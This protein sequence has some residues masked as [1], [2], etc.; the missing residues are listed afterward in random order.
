MVAHPLPARP[1][2]SARGRV[3]VLVMAGLLGTMACDGGKSSVSGPA[4]TVD[5]QP[6]LPADAAPDVRTA[7]VGPAPDR[8]ISP[9]DGPRDAAPPPIDGPVATDA[10]PL[11]DHPSLP[12]DADTSDAAPVVEG[13]PHLRLLPSA[14]MLREAREPA[15]VQVTLEGDATEAR[16]VTFD[17]PG[18][19][20]DP[21]SVTLNADTRQAVVHLIAPVDADSDDSR[22]RLTANAPDLAPVSVPYVVR[23]AHLTWEMVLDQDQLNFVRNSNDKGTRLHIGTRLN[24]RDAPGATIN[25]RGKGTL[26]CPRR[27]FTVRFDRPVQIQDSPPL[28][29]V[30]LI[31]LCEDPLVIRSRISLEML[32][33]IG[34]FPSW[35]TYVELQ[36]GGGTRGVYMLIERPRNAIARQFP[37]NTRVLR[38]MNDHDVEIDEPDEAFIADREAFLAS[39]STLYTLRSQFQ[40]EALLAELQRRMMYDQYLLWLAYNSVMA[41]GDYI[42]ELYVYDRGPPAD[43][44]GAE[45]TFYGIMPWDQDEIFRNCHTPAPINEP[46]LNCAES[47]LDGLVRS[48][49]PIRALYVRQLRELMAG[50]LE[51]GTMEVVVARAA[52]ELAVYLARPGVAAMH[53]VANMP[54]PDGA[55][56]RDEFMRLLR[57]R[58]DILQPIVDQEPAP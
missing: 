32:S 37:E 10:G 49:P 41:D 20:V 43:R 46:L 44:V 35:T 36:Y 28:D 55:T 40:G 33:K 4:V 39:Y 34:I 50:P 17:A 52:A 18:M 22:G 54:P 19:T 8:A 57:E 56:S 26:V 31:A 23:D 58:R 29:D 6:S 15:L 53:T 5:A 30:V 47:S 14:L 21:P 1:A 51:P 25:L 3:L 42:D 27:S 16:T 2:R 13:P 45:A 48:Q 12:P 11:P 9:P 38:R 24:G 7:D